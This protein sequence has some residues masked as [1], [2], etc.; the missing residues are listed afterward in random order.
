V[1][2]YAHD[3]GDITHEFTAPADGFYRFDVSTNPGYLRPSVSVYDG[4]EGAVLACSPNP[5]LIGP[6][7][8]DLAMTAGQ[9]VIVVV[10][11]SYWL[12]RGD[13]ELTVSQL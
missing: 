10:D 7:H 8:V 2:S 12:D 13:Y 9:V 1:D 3:T 5:I 4:C 6:S 11:G